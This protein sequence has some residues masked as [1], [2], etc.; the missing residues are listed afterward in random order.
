MNRFHVRVSKCMVIRRART[1]GVPLGDNPASQIWTTP[2]TPWEGDIPEWR[3]APA[4]E[5]VTADWN[6]GCAVRAIGR[7]LGVS[8]D[9]VARRVKTLGLVR[10]HAGPPHKGEAPTPR[11]RP[12]NI[13]M[14]LVTL[15][16]LA[17]H[18]EPPRMGTGHIRRAAT[19]TC[20][21]IVSDDAPWMFCELPATIKSYCTH[22]AKV[23]WV[24]MPVGV[25][26]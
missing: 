19:K 5:I 13:P 4:D 25:A 8:E 17:S 15:S 1:I 3:T 23:A 18:Q 21:W 9:A 12:V 2:L 20:Q 22:H 24:R 16:P 26:A 7:R 6:A 10:R 11:T 14:P